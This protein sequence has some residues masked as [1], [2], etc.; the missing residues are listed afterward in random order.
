[1]KTQI[2][3]SFRN[4]RGL[5]MRLPFPW[6]DFIKCTV[7]WSVQYWPFLL[8]QFHLGASQKAVTIVIRLMLTSVG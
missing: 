6:T 8:N 5:L 2:C 3:L 1:M 4:P 7:H